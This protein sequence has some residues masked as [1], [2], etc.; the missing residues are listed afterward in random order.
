MDNNQLREESDRYFNT[1]IVGECGCEDCCTDNFI[2]AQE[3]IFER[4]GVPFVPY[5]FQNNEFEL[6]SN[7]ESFGYFWSDLYRIQRYNKKQEYKRDELGTNK[8][9]VHCIQCGRLTYKN[10]NRSY[11]D[12]QLCLTCAKYF[13]ECHYCNKLVSVRMDTVHTIHF[14]DTNETINACRDCYY[15]QHLKDNKCSSCRYQ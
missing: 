9:L 4:F 5:N 1:Y 3:D 10:K 12:E 13:K 11:H 15:S 14:E 8:S 2:E 6:G 7:I